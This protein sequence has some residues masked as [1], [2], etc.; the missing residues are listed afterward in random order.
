MAEFRFARRGRS[1]HD[2]QSI[3]K[4]RAQS[5]TP[6]R[7]AIRLSIL[8][9]SPAAH[10]SKQSSATVH[11]VPLR[12]SSPPG[13]HPLLPFLTPP[14]HK[15]SLRLQRGEWSMFKG[16]RQATNDHVPPPLPPSPQRHAPRLLIL[17]APHSRHG[18]KTLGVRLRQF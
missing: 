3:C 18:D 12:L 2:F 8:Q 10:P 14:T 4:R 5:V 1:V 15:G 6:V 9:E 17:L 7:R 16:L 13:S 11:R